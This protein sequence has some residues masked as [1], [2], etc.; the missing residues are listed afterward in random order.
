M[1]FL[2]MAVLGFF[3]FAAFLFLGAARL[4]VVFFLVDLFFVFA[5]DFAFFFA[6]VSSL[7]SLDLR[8]WKWF[9][10]FQTHITHDYFF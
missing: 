9:P 5:F 1:L 3:L 10:T 2:I 4:F 6:M 8:V 7:F